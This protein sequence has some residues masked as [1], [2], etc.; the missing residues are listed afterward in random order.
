MRHSG[1]DGS[2]NS[3]ARR[4]ETLK[5]SEKLGG[6]H[7]RNCISMALMDYTHS[8]LTNKGIKHKLRIGAFMGDVSSGLTA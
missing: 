8:K 5:E 7:G 6:G 3:R 1:R 2:V 4:V